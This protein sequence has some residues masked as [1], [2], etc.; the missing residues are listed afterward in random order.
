M[1]HYHHFVDFNF[2]FVCFLRKIL[3]RFSCAHSTRMQCEISIRKLLQFTRNVN[4]RMSL[5][6]F[7]F[8]WQHVLLFIIIRTFTSRPICSDGEV[9]LDFPRTAIMKLFLFCWLS[10]FLFFSFRWLGISQ[11]LTQFLSTFVAPRTQRLHVHIVCEHSRAHV[12]ICMLVYLS[13]SSSMNYFNSPLNNLLVPPAMLRFQM[14][15]FVVV[16]AEYGPKSKSFNFTNDCLLPNQPNSQ[17][18]Q[19][20]MKCTNFA[21]DFCSDCS[22]CIRFIWIEMCDDGVMLIW[23]DMW[24]MTMMDGWLLDAAMFNWY[25]FDVVDVA[26]MRIDI[27]SRYVKWSIY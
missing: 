13:I 23:V 14:D 16:A 24:P 10:V 26:P 7:Q 6:R 22:I 9:D 4:T 3:M 1:F 19:S 25:K 2:R 27:L 8:Q 11:S 18:Q 15:E 21:A 5:K 12:W 20:S 17:N